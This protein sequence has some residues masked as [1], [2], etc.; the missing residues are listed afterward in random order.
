MFEASHKTNMGIAVPL[1][2][3]N[4]RLTFANKPKALSAPAECPSVDPREVRARHS[5]FCWQ[6]K[7][8]LAP[9]SW[10]PIWRRTALLVVNSHWLALSQHSLSRDGAL[11]TKRATWRQPTPT[12]VTKRRRATDNAKQRHGATAGDGKR[13]ARLARSSHLPWHRAVAHSERTLWPAQLFRGQ[14]R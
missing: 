13:Q 14:N 8:F 1:P 6:T 11:A 9:T 7:L 5:K 2:S 12:R 4:P 3:D 10:V